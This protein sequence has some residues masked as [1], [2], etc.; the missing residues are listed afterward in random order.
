MKR[1]NVPNPIQL[2]DPDEGREGQK[3]SFAK[4]VRHA[5]LS[6]RKFGADYEG[7]R[8]AFAIDQAVKSG[9]FADLELADWEKL[10][11]VAKAPSAGA[12][13]GFHPLALIQLTP[14]LEAIIGASDAPAAPRPE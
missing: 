8:A 4:F 6:D 5:L 2:L 3:L 14:F 7:I 11:D 12:Y 1:I 10:R 13:P 9:P